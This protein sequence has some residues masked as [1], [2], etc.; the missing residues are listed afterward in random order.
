MLFV[1]FL[2]CFYN[3]FTRKSGVFVSIDLCKLNVKLLD[4]TT[5]SCIRWKTQTTVS[6]QTSNRVRL[7]A[8]IVNRKDSEHFDK[9]QWEPVVSIFAFWA[10]SGCWMMSYYFCIADY[11]MFCRV[12][13]TALLP[14]VLTFTESAPLSYPLHRTLWILNRSSVVLM[15]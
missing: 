13:T 2:M 8:P 15:M 4:Q 11:Q 3:L 12:S 5:V 6:A 1:S 7:A 10:F 9:Q 14:S